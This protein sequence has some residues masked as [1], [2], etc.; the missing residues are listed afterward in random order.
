[1]DADFYL[2]IFSIIFGLLLDF[3]AV[4]WLYIKYDIPIKDSLRKLW[5]EG[6]L[7]AFKQA[8]TNFIPVTKKVIGEIWKY[9]KERVPGI[10]KRFKEKFKAKPVRIN[11]CSLF[12]YLSLK[13]VA[14][15]YAYNLFPTEIYPAYAE[16]PP[17]IDV[18]F[19][20]KSAITEDD[21][22]EIIWA[23]RAKFKDYMRIFHRIDCPC[24]AVPNVLDNYIGVI[25]YYCVLPED[26]PAYNNRCNQIMQMR[27]TPAFRPLTEADLPKT[28]DF[29]LGYRYEKW[30]TTGQVVP[31]IWNVAAAPHIMVS[32]PTSGGKSVYIKILLSQI[33][34]T[35]ASVCLCDYKGQSD[36]RG[37]L[38]DCSIG[39]QCDARLT[40]FCADFEKARELGE[41][42]VWKI[43]VF[44]EFGS[45]AASKEKKEWEKLMK[46]I[47]S[48]V[49]MGRSYKYSI[50]LISQRFDADTIKTSLREQFSVKVYMGPTISQQ[51]ATILYP[52]SE[53]DKSTRLPP[54]CGYISTPK[55][56][57]DTIILPKVDIPALD[58]RLKALGENTQE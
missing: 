10:V 55:T 40:Q 21:E 36:Y 20:T 52:N 47:S 43:L 57:L 6:Y 7:E 28:S 53:V 34:A 5:K 11:Y 49:F 3:G 51:A 58:R 26:Y 33:L 13:G 38:K 25:L 30:T 31:I 48:V 37:L 44:D 19:Y 4:L 29:V 54:C 41:E 22:A 2:L 1:M 23:L 18:S 14:K 39:D 17:H 9:I 8:W 42:D 16:Q 46:T 27:S 56:D 50:V 32:G 35:D 24:F 12:L 45:F 15:D